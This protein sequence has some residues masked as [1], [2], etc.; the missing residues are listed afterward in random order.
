M[1]LKAPGILVFMLSIILSL[2]V[3]FARYFGSSVPLLTGE[4]TQFYAMMGAYIVL[5]FGCIMRG[6]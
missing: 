5:L 6:L 3:L 2:G 1:A 4:T